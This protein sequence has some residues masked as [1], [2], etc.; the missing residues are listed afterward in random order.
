M[1]RE[2]LRRYFPRH[3]AEGDYSQA[4]FSDSLKFYDNNLEGALIK[5]YGPKTY[6]ELAFDWDGQY[7]S[8]R[9]EQFNAFGYGKYIFNDFVSAGLAFKYH[10]YANAAEY[11]SVVDDAMV[12]PFVRLV[13]KIMRLAGHFCNIGLVPVIA[14]GQASEGWSE[15]S[16]RRGVYSVIAKL[17]CRH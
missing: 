5:A 8:Y 15:Q 13:S 12:Q 4:F 10:H 17:E 9:R 6:L 14:A 1:E 2:G 7:G 11:G 16:R 3:L